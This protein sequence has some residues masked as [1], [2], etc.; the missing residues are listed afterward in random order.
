MSDRPPF[1][2][3]YVQHL[4]NG[5]FA[6]TTDP[7]A[8]AGRYFHQTH[9]SMIDQLIS[10]MQPQLTYRGYRVGREASLQIAEGREP[11]IFVQ[12]SMSGI[13]PEDRWSYELAA[14]EVLAEP[15]IALESDIPLQAIHIR[16]GSLVTVVELI[17]PANKEKPSEIQQYRMR[18]ER[19]L[20]EKGVN[21]VEIDL[22]RSIKRAVHDPLIN[23]FPYHVMVYVPA[24]APRLIGI[25]WGK[26]LPRIALP[27]RAEVIPV[28]LQTAYSRAYQLLT[29]AGQINDE[30]RYT[31]DELPFPSV[32]SDGQRQ[33][34]LET[35]TQWQAELIQLGKAGKE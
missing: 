17:S 35:V 6:G 13:E 20:V 31:D 30:E 3:A 32:F 33:Q 9:S 10:Q 15:G 7:W 26:P 29:I 19:L 34:L 16:Q 28:D 2:Q 1:S 11:D 22:T 23:D 24:Q 4:M 5:P 21:I 12:R 8:E 18:R 14:V 27:L 25:E